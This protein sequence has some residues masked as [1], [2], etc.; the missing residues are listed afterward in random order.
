MRLCLV[1]G[2]PSPGTREEQ[3]AGADAEQ[4]LPGQEEIPLKTPARHPDQS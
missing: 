3:D 4:A 2:G 1:D